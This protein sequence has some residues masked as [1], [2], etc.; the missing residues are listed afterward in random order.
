MTRTL[1]HVAL[2]L[3]AAVGTLA[4]APV[5]R[6]AAQSAPPASHV[7][8]PHTPP[9]HIRSIAVAG[10]LAV[11]RAPV[12]RADAGRVARPVVVDAGA[13]FTM[14]GLVC[15]VPKADGAVTVRLGTSP[16][17]REWSPWLDVPLEVVAEA[18][19]APRAFTEAVWTGAAR[20][21]R[22]LATGAGGA[23]VALAHVRL[24]SLDPEVGH[25]APAE[26]AGTT[27]RHAHAAAPRI[28]TRREWGADEA[29]RGD[30][31]HYAKVKMAFV[32]HTDS[33]NDYSAAEAPAV[34]R[35]IYA[36]HTR[37]L[38][39]SD[40]GYNF[41]VDR[42]GTI[43]EGRYGGIRRGVVGAQVLGFNRGSV[44]ISLIGDFAGDAPPAE[45][46]AALEKLLTWKLK[47]HH[48]KPTGT[49]KI[50][51]DYGQRYRTG[52][53]VTFPVV[54]GHRQ[55]NN[56]ECPGNVLYPLLTTVRL[57]AAGK[58]QPPIVTLVKASPAYFSPNGD[59]AG[60]TAGV[61]LWLT[62][63]AGWNVELRDA[64][65]ERLGSYSGEGAYY[66]VSW[67][68]NDPQGRA[69]P[70]G[71]YTAVVTASTDL[72]AAAPRSVKL[73][74]DTVAPVLAGADVEPDTF[75]ANGDGWAE[76]AKL[77]Y[78]AAERC[79]TRV[80]ILDA[81]GKVRRRLTEWR[82]ASSAEQT[83]TWNGEVTAGGAAVPTEDGQY[84]F[85]LEC[86]DAAGNVSRQTVPV[87]LDCTVGF[88]TATPDVVSPNGD[89]VNDAATLGFT[90]TR[91]ATV[92]L[93]VKVSGKAVRTF[94]LGPLEAGSHAVAWDGT[95]ESGAPVASGKLTFSVAGTSALGTCS[96]T[97]RFTADLEQ[98]TL[99]VVAPRSVALGKSAR[100]SCTPQ[101]AYSP[102][103]QLGFAIADALGVVVASGT[104]GWVPVGTAATWSWK[105]SVVGLYTLTCTAVDRGGNRELA[106][107]IGLLIVQ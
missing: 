69:F 81:D 71:S 101:D 30:R 47:L 104:R 45:A 106:P 17:G 83:S 56:T 8:A 32:H 107:A 3:A 62:K 100:L 51:C 5:P 87:V 24:V 26:Q 6:A 86:R 72:G 89:G 40:I 74:I 27:G 66:K 10:G 15:A 60:D 64:G 53:K 7:A 97:G 35:A 14:A 23:P 75:S 93:A 90:L 41:L 70:D 1:I 46:L 55:A 37:S 82:D 20:Y 65:G 79:A 67:P 49:A 13:S 59:G 91:A 18:G 52:Q 9:V 85:L 36:Y 78:K 42:F 50:R 77:T 61:S 43:Y 12:G 63:P 19:G 2:A 80:S 33:G 68:G 11:G 95:A 99:T 58:P 21:V 31:P 48:L 44:G 88:L 96:A 102:D 94:S 34:M 76:T 22:L 57:E 105:P 98:P 4:A 73:V 39:W 92:K 103:V 38:G 29:L 16:D 28:V 84:S 54:A 25:P